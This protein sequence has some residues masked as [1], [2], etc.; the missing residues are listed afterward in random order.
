M[1]GADEGPRP[2]LQRTFVIFARR[3][4]CLTHVEQKGPNKQAALDAINDTVARLEAE[5][6]AK[7]AAVVAERTQ[8]ERLQALL[9]AMDDLDLAYDKDDAAAAAMAAAAAIKG[10]AKKDLAVAAQPV[11]PPAA[12]DGE[13]IPFDM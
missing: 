7:K 1:Q 9:D 2:W 4:H 6:A 10:A 12:D 13:F 11:G 5:L 3:L 8:E